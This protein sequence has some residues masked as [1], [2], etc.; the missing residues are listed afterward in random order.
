MI[1]GIRSALIVDKKY[2]RR[3]HLIKG[4][5]DFYY[6]AKSMKAETSFYVEALGIK[7]VVSDEHWEHMLV[8]EDLDGNVLKLMK[9]KY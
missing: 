4:Y 5:Q 8:F 2:L 9:S 3:A 6:N 1:P 7:I